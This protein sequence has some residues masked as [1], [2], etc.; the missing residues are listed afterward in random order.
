MV[1]RFGRCVVDDVEEARHGVGEGKCDVRVE[2]GSGYLRHEHQARN[3]VLYECGTNQGDLEEVYQV[4]ILL[5]R[6]GSSQ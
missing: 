3:I 6:R 4:D 5:G 2:G 1:T